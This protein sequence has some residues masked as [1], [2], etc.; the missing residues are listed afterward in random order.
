MTC[1]DL[2][3]EAS[4]QQYSFSFDTNITNPELAEEWQKYTEGIS[5]K[6]IPIERA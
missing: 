4:S 3:S 1:F 2:V 6:I 5:K